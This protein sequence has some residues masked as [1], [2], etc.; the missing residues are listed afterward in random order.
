MLSDAASAVIDWTGQGLSWVNQ[1]YPALT[2]AVTSACVLV[3]WR[4]WRFTILPSYHPN[5]P[6]ELPYWIPCKL[7]P[8]SIEYQTNHVQ[9]WVRIFCEPLLRTC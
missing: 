5:D 2:V 7:T 9:S 4:I 1:E 8:L 6:K 3:L